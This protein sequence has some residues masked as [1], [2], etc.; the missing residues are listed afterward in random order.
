[1][2]D[3]LVEHALV[4]LLGD[5]LEALEERRRRPQSER[6]HKLLAVIF[7]VVHRLGIER[8]PRV[9]G[10]VHRVERHAF[11]NVVRVARPRERPLIEQIK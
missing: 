11:V 4:L 9:L 8:P 6:E 7:L 10:A 3:H 5:S 1:M 2:E